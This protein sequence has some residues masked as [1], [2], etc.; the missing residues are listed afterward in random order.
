MRFRAELGKKWLVYSFSAANKKVNSLP[1]FGDYSQV[2]TPFG[3][4]MHV[5]KGDIGLTI[6]QGNQTIIASVS[7][8]AE[9][10]DGKVDNLLKALDARE[11]PVPMHVQSR[12]KEVV[13]IANRAPDPEEFFKNIFG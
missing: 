12:L 9:E 2:L 1:D 10:S 13:A 5:K 3:N 7:N 8:T 11:M 6:S 4:T